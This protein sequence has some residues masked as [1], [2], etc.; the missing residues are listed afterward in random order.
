MSFDRFRAEGGFVV[1]ADMEEGR[2]VRVEV[3]ATVDRTLRLRDPFGA[4]EADWDREVKR[5]G[6]DLTMALKA[7]E[8]LT[9]VLAR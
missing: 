1:S 9:G 4:A 6:D 2:A 3:L 7:G 8:T 5:D